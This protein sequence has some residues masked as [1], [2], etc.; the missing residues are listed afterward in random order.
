MA[1]HRLWLGRAVAGVFSPWSWIAT[2]LAL[3]AAGPT[4][5]TSIDPHWPEPERA[6]LDPSWNA[7]VDPDA[8]DLSG[9]RFGEAVRGRPEALVDLHGVMHPTLEEGP[10]VPARPMEALARP[11]AIRFVADP[12]EP[13]AARLDRKTGGAPL[14]WEIRSPSV[15][16]EVL[17]NVP[18]NVAETSRFGMR[19]ALIT[20]LVAGATV[21]PPPEPEAAVQIQTREVR[22]VETEAGA[23]VLDSFDDRLPIAILL[24]IVILMSAAILVIAR[25]ATPQPQLLRARRFGHSGRR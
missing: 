12:T 13:N 9:R 14:P 24:A 3:G 8:P 4:L 10:A 5:A 11:L 6:R 25:P 16:A 19:D 23:P 18:E 17:R 2:G 7:G 22:P 1:A 21:M 15:F 20:G